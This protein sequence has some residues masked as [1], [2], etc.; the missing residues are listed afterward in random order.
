MAPVEGQAAVA[1]LEERCLLIA[2]PMLFSLT[3]QE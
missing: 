3:A 2:M 1:L